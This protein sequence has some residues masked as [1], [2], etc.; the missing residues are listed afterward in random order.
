MRHSSPNYSELPEG[1]ELG[2]PWQL[3]Q[4]HKPK[5]SQHAIVE[6][7]PH[8]NAADLNQR[9]VF[10][11][12]GTHSFPFAYPFISSLSASPQGLHIAYR[13]GRNELIGVYW[14]R[15]GLG[16][17][18]AFL[19]C[20]CGHKGDRLFHTRTGLR[21]RFCANAVYISQTKGYRSRPLF[22]ACKL[23]LE[24]GTIPQTGQKIPARAK[25]K[26][27]RRYHRLRSMIESLERKAKPRPTRPDDYKVFAYYTG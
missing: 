3:Q 20:F 14:F 19:V 15:T 12:P 11:Q 16:G 6:L 24:L 7:L 4:A 13:N 23:R 21:C 10:T 1:I 18:R 27:R 5:R 25:G 22:Q 9:G 17:L 8:I 2:M 26:H